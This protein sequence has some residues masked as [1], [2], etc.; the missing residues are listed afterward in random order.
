MRLTEELNKYGIV[1]KSTSKKADFAKLLQE[2]AKIRDPHV[3]NNI[4]QDGNTPGDGFSPTSYWD[5]K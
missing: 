4:G 3:A 5:F 2:S 1:P